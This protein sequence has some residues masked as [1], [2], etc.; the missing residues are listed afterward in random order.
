L[1]ASKIS[2]SLLRRRRKLDVIRILDHERNELM[3]H[4][5]CEIANSIM[6]YILHLYGIYMRVIALD[7][8]V[9]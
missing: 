1:C 8:F 3:S 2:S 5:E 4:G 7:V 6:V 9:A